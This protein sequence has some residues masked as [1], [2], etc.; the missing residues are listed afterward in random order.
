MTQI[1]LKI[2]IVISLIQTFAHAN[3]WITHEKAYSVGL[4]NQDKKVTLKLEYHVWDG[5]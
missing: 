3:S 2:F 1:I 5:A 4:G